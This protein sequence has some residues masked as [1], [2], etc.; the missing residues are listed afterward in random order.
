[1]QTIGERLANSL[2]EE[3]KIA[4]ELLEVLQKE[5]DSLVAADVESL[6]NLTKDK[7]RI[8]SRMS[9]LAKQRYDVLAEAGFD[10]SETGMQA[11]TD[12]AAA[13][14]A[15]RDA[16]KA[17]LSLARSG[18]EHNRINGLLIS[19]HMSSNQSALRVL[20]SHAQ[21]GN[22]YGPDGQ[23]TGKVGGRHLGAG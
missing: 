22:F 19:Q 9:D 4:S 6:M 21:G 10:A 20:Y 3:Q 16:W 11:W 2:S 18:K 7:A 5:Q 23:S 13:T 14:P 12:S 8:A 15:V 17:L 1:M